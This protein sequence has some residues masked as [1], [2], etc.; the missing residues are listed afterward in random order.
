MWGGCVVCVRKLWSGML[1]FVGICVE[2]V[3]RMWRIV[4]FCEGQ[5]LAVLLIMRC[6]YLYLW[7][8]CSI[9]IF[10]C[11]IVVFMPGRWGRMEEIVKICAY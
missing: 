11:G 1:V 10:D 4:W 2:I 6:L 3:E 9:L 5:L 7:S 8:V